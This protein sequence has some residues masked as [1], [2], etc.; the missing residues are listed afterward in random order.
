MKLSAARIADMEVTGKRYEK[1]VEPGSP[2]WVRVEATADRSGKAR[3]KYVCRTVIDRKSVRKIIGPVSEWTL[4]EAKRKALAIDADARDNG[5]AEHLATA[6]AVVGAQTGPCPNS[7]AEK[8]LDYME[9]EG[10]HKVSSKEKWTHYWRSIEPQWGARPVTSIAKR[11]CVALLDLELKAAKARGETGTS[12]N[13]LHKVLARFFNWVAGQGYIEVSPMTGLKKKIDVSLTR[14][15]PRPL[16]EQELIWLFQALDRLAGP[17]ANAIE[18]LLRSVCRI[19]NILDAKKENVGERGLLLPKTKNFTALMV[20]L[21]DSMK[22]LLGDTEGAG[23]IWPGHLRRKAGFVDEELRPMMEEI[24]RADGFNGTFNVEHF[25]D[26]TRNLDFWTP[27]NFRDTA[28]TWFENQLDADD[29]PL[30][31]DHVQKAMLNHRPGST[32][33]KHYSAV[34]LDPLWMYGA[35]KKAGAAWN[36]YLDAVKA[37]ALDQ[38]KLAA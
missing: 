2:L 13:N 29:D 9:T 28:T 10:K 16:N 32:K 27:H 35:R 20:P 30:F 36:A 1:A 37:K 14:R 21:T 17:R 23:N 18:F 5:G 22:A 34:A 26:K 8:F 3:S 25:A 6:K 15:P 33:D 38:L 24:A 19:G 4:S 31:P 12:A 7:V 11:D